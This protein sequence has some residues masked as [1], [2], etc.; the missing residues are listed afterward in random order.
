MKTKP[1]YFEFEKQFNFALFC[2]LPQFTISQ[3][4]ST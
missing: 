4:M 1:F 3:A 2:A